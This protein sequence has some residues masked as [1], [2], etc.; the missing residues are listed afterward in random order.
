MPPVDLG[1]LG[2]RDRIARRKRWVYG[3]I[4]T[5]DVWLSFAIVRTGYAATVFAFAYDLVAKRM[6]ADRTVLGPTAV[7]R[8]ADDF[9]APGEV[10]Q[11]QL[12]KRHVSLVR[13]GSTLDVRVRLD[14][15]AIDASIDERSGPPAITAIAAV[16]APGEG[17]LN[18]TE[19]RVL[20]DVQGR[21]VCA[22]R[23]LSL[24][25]GSAGY[26]YTHGLLPRHTTWRWAFAQGRS[27]AGEPFAFNVVQGFVG[28]AECAA[29][30]GG[31]VIPIAEPSFD[32]DVAQP[33]KPWR[34]T[35]RGIDL[36]FAPGAVHEQH[37]KLVIVRSRFVQPVGVFTGTMRIDGRDILLDGLPGVVE[38]QDVL[39]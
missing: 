5:G 9:H 1:P 23:E 12:G 2:L 25:G 28:E 30:L 35:G 18:A 17:L 24:D 39:W 36:T 26:D 22:G 37:T 31:A 33:G 6:L 20:L 21:A 34:L 13:T 38:D 16:G 15:I 11:F 8:V 3:A 29:F 10:A 32:F 27:A 4:V 7:A 19:K 14:D